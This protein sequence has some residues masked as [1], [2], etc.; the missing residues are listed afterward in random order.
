M[1]NRN[2]DSEIWNDSK[3]ADEFSPEDKYF[4]LLLLTTRYGNLAGCFSFT[5]SQMSK[6]SGYDEN[7][8]K[9][10]LGRFI[11]KYKVV[12]YDFT[13]KEILIFNWYKYNW[14]K[15]PK[16]K[17]VMSKYIAKIKSSHLKDFGEKLFQGYGIDTVSIGYRYP[18]S[19]IS[20]SDSVSISDSISISERERN[21]QS[22]PP[23]ADECVKATY[24]KY[25]NVKLTNEQ[26]DELRKTYPSLYQDYI[27]RLDR[28]IGKTGRTYQDHFI[29]IDSWIN[30]DQKISPIKKGVEVIEPSQDLV[31]DDDYQ[32][33]LEEL[34]NGKLDGKEKGTSVYDNGKS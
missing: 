9:I 2:I 11:N 15:S 30:E 20:I 28:H 29:V 4:W 24:G 31:S 1:A 3:F 19:S 10:I 27:D 32:K 13:T 33:L 23:P 34:K 14:T 8:I 6:D 5:I 25:K 26:Y 16:F 18:T 12:D 21:Q 17:I 22:S 7:S